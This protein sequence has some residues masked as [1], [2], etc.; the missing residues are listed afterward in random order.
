MSDNNQNVNNAVA[1]DNVKEPANKKVE[2]ENINK[3]KEPAELQV[4]KLMELFDVLSFNA[5]KSEMTDKE[6][7]E[8]I[9]EVREQTNLSKKVFLMNLNKANT[10][11]H[12]TI[13]PHVAKLIKEIKLLS[14]LSEKHTG[15]Y[16]EDNVNAIFEVIKKKTNEVKKNLKSKNEKEDPFSL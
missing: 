6:A 3:F 9:A 11:Q 1:S 16:S 5:T 7:D 12:G 14:N 10:Q 2:K 4:N 8:L 13:T 15:E